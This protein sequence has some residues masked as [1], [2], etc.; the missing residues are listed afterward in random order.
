MATGLERNIAGENMYRKLLS[1]LLKRLFRHFE[2]LG[3]HVLPVHYYSPI[4]EIRKL[5]IDL[6]QKISDLP[7]IEINEDFQLRLLE[8][9]QYKLYF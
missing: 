8:E 6:W 4:P 1:F 3:V 5:G 7:R 2:R 9:L